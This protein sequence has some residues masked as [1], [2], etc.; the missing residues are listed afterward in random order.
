MGLGGI[1]AALVILLVQGCILPAAGQS[2]CIVP[3]RQDGWRQK[4]QGMLLSSHHQYSL[5][6]VKLPSSDK[7]RA[8]GVM[9]GCQ[10]GRTRPSQARPGHG[11][12]Q[13]ANALQWWLR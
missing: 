5:S 3:V 4:E 2:V 12:R 7:E 6:G 13:G 1:Q 8:S 11:S 9:L 10:E